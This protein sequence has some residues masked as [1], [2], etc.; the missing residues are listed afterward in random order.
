MYKKSTMKVSVHHEAEGWVV[1]KN[2]N[3]KFLVHHSGPLCVVLGDTFQR[4]EICIP[5]IRT[6]LP[7]DTENTTRLT[8]QATTVSSQLNVWPTECVIHGYLSVTVFGS[9]STPAPSV[10]K[11]INLYTITQCLNFPLFTWIF[12]VY[13]DT[14]SVISITCKLIKLN[15][16]TGIVDLDFFL[17]HSEMRI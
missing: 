15:V 9:L 7:W 11:I 10:L 3:V 8:I 12:F 14:D 13:I 4:K 1:Y 17:S 2:L 6:R 5:H 16:W